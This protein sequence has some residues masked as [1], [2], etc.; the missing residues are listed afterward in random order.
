MAGN[1]F[2]ARVRNTLRL[3]IYNIYLIVIIINNNNNVFPVKEAKPVDV[4][5]LV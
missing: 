5:S 2:A 1:Q 4:D 3:T